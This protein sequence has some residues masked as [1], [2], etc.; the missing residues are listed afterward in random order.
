[1]PREATDLLSY[2]TEE[3]TEALTEKGAFPK[4]Q[5]RQSGRGGGRGQRDPAQRKAEEG[6]NWRIRG[7]AGCA[8]GEPSWDLL[9]SANT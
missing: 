6:I 5:S 4:A 2:M 9:N 3:G 7:T 8:H 1:M